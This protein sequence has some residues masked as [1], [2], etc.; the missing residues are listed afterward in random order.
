ME[1]DRSNKAMELSSREDQVRSFDTKGCEGGI[2]CLSGEEEDIGGS[3]D[4]CDGCATV[5]GVELGEGVGSVGAEVGFEGAF[6]FRLDSWVVCGGGWEGF[7][8]LL[9]W[10]GR[11][12]T[13]VVVIFVFG[14]G[15]CC[16]VVVRFTM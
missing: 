10:W 15:M 12:L 4:G 11:W 6:E 7:L 16:T 14:R 3:E 13:V 2:E 1:E 9:A 8:L 5:G